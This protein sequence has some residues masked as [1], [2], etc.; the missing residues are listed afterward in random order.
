MAEPTTQNVVNP[1]TGEVGS[2]LPEKLARAQ[3]AGVRQ[4]SGDEAAAYLEEQRHDRD[5]G[6]A[7]AAHVIGKVR[8]V[9]EAFG[10]P[11]DPL[12][13]GVASAFGKSDET[14]NYLN[15]LKRWQPGES[16]MGELAGQVG[17]SVA[18][19]ELLGGGGGLARAPSAAG[20]IV[21]SAGSSAVRGGLENLII[22]STSDIN[23]AAL[24]NTDLAGEK[25]FAEMPKHFVTG[26]LAG[27]LFGAGGE[28][29]AEG[30]GA[31]KRSLPT[32]LER[33]A[34]EAVG[35]EIGGGLEEG[36]AL[37]ARMGK[38]PVSSTEIAD[39]LTKEQAAYRDASQATALRA[40]GDVE[41][42]H[43]TAA[44]QQSAKAEADRLTSAMEAKAAVEAVEAGH[45]TA[46]KAI[47]DEQ[48]KATEA[49]GKL[50][51]ERATAQKQLRSLATD[52]DKVKGAELPSAKNIMDNATAQ[53]APAANPSLTPPSPRAVALF[54]EW[55]NTFETRF[56]ETG[57][58]KFTELQDVVKSL[59]VMEKRQ[60][61]VSGW[62]SDPE[63][64]RAFDALKK[65]ARDEFDRASDITAGSVSE[66]KGLHAARLRAS[67]PELDNA[68]ASAEENVGKL[69]GVARDFERGAAQEV[70]E[71][72]RAGFKAMRGKEKVLRAEESAMNQQQRAELRGLPKA[73]TKTPVDAQLRATK[74]GG[75]DSGIGLMSMGGAAMSLLHGNVAGAAMS[76]M[77]GL[78]AHTA[79]AQGN[80]LA[81]RTMSGLAERIAKAD[82][83]IA[84]YA[85][86]TV[87]RYARQSA[88]VSQEATASRPRL[89]FEKVAQ[90]VRDAESNPLI[91][92]QR[93]R[94]VA[95]DWAAQAPGVYSSLLSSA[96]RSQQ[97]LSSKLPPA[98]TD[99]YSLTQHLETDDLSDTEKYDFV[100][101][102]KA[103]SDPVE[104][105]KDVADGS[106][107]P[108]QVE[109]IQAV[110]PQ[111]Y[112]QMKAE[113]L[114]RV[115]DLEH[116]LDYERS[117][118]IGTLLNVDTNEVMTGEFQS[119]LSNMYSTREKNEQI[120]GGSKPRGVNSRLSKSSASAGQQMQ[121]G[122][123]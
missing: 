17:G 113:V 4:M 107:T 49:L 70:R 103:V 104:V 66:A 2:V 108:Q 36:A 45:V 79:K 7:Y 29:L 95:G 50:T 85:G 35:K 34:S 43:T 101:Y 26:A 55:A 28:V 68:V 3:A 47:A 118:N 59:D 5:F 51:E 62:G 74:S 9:G 90:R 11:V 42:A 40:R 1:K 69:D 122:D 91:I 94:S 76:V 71:A 58:M 33:R 114:R 110:Y 20:R 23:E 112:G 84:R 30:A 75:V 8:G 44:W 60:R 93:V 37:R 119:M 53:F 117:V 88:E 38:T 72:E 67:I 115:A 77:G 25:L 65:S 121:M 86:R 123:S 82:G 120:D 116:P 106:V 10:L 22:G 81:A 19:G 63:V 83:A 32:A 57:K 109:A 78:A 102:A 31:L 56:G 14:R 39:F 24:G 92:E 99:P 61:V 105:L 73:A 6:E 12:A 27:G 52:L 41:G 100:Q 13:T 18:G 46:R 16:A 96:V 111:L 89:T 48:T 64:K 97:F 87:G 98:R 54:N 15:E 21:Q 80:L